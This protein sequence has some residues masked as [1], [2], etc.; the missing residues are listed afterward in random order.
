MPTPLERSSLD[1][2]LGAADAALR[3][4]LAQSHAD[5]PS[6]AA[7][8]P[9]STLAAEDR[10]LSG[11]LMRVNHV[12]EVCAQAMYS[13]QS[14]VARPAQLRHSLEEAAAEEMDHLAWT[15]ERLE[16]LGTR[17]SL[18]NPLWY[19]GAFGFGLLAGAFGTRASLG[20][21]AETERQVQAHLESHLGR[22]PAMDA[23]SRAIVRRMRDEE[24]HHGEAARN[25]GGT[26]LPSP[27]TT[28]MKL[29]A[30]V[31]TLTAH[32]V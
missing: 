12:G 31:M 3:T 30:R 19:A 6:P 10:K 27:V 8:V 4:V 13:A 21:V 23:K 14:L 7:D 24:A 11:A 20:F 29:A 2:V 26:N 5:R 18:L 17:P 32:R 25:A 28:A 1:R 22:L 16:Q 9:E 15:R